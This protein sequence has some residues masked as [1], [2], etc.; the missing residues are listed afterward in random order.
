[1]DFYPTLQPYIPK[2]FGLGHTFTQVT[3]DP[4]TMS[5][6]H[7]LIEEEEGAA[8]L[9]PAK[10]LAVGECDCARCELR[11][12]ISV[13]FL[14]ALEILDENTECDASALDEEKRCRAVRANI[15]SAA[16]HTINQIEDLL[17]RPREPLSETFSHRYYVLRQ[18]YNYVL[19]ACKSRDEGEVLGAAAMFRQFHFLL[20][21]VLADMHD[22]IC[23]AASSPA[24]DQVFFERGTMAHCMLRNCHGIIFCRALYEKLCTIADPLQEAVAELKA[25]PQDPHCTGHVIRPV[26]RAAAANDEDSGTDVD[27]VPDVV[28]TAAAASGQS[29]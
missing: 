29:K 14:S 23:S 6:K 24:G 12:E 11:E 20:R 2:D 18:R 27:T 4:K 21:H 22:D 5:A 3:S 15:A 7:N 1:M 8:S 17:R 19:A 26:P 25:A 28:Q 13:M 9:P 16:S 10:K